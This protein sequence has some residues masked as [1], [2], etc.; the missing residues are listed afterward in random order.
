MAVCS[1]GGRGLAPQTGAHGI[2]AWRRGVPTA[3]QTGAHG[4]QAGGAA[5]LRV[6]VAVSVVGAGLR[7][8]PHRS[9]APPGRRCV[10]TPP[11]I[12]IASRHSPFP[13]SPPISGIVINCRHSLITVKADLRRRRVGVLHIQGGAAPL[14]LPGVSIDGMHLLLATGAD[15]R[16]RQATVRCPSWRRC[17][18][19]PPGHSIDGGHSITTASSPHDY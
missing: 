4:I 16:R 15:L 19:T 13:A 8:G 5:S 2:Q 1:M 3:P 9:I 14:R 11:G 12:V 10:P 7:F 6:M 17:V 18:P